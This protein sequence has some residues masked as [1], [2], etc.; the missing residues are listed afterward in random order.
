M[1]FGNRDLHR[2]QTRR[3]NSNNSHLRICLFHGTGNAGDQSASAD[4]RDN[5]LDIRDLLQNFQAHRALACNYDLIIEGMDE[6]H[7]ELLAAADGLFAGLVVIRAVKDDFGA[8]ALCRRSLDQRRRQRH[9]DLRANSVTAGVVGDSLGVVPRRG[10][11]Y[12]AGTL[13]GSQRQQ[14]V[15]RAAFLESAGALQ[16][17]ELEIN[18]IPGV[19][20]EIFRA[21]A[22]R[23]IDGVT[24][25]SHGRLDFG[26][27]H[28]RMAG[29]GWLRHED[30]F[31]HCMESGSKEFLSPLWGYY[32]LTACP[33]LAPWAALFRRFAAEL[34]WLTFA[35]T[36]IKFNDRSH[37]Y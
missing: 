2:W 25:A 9:T 5:G 37:G 30:W 4:R 3:L 18:R 23:Q 1:A 8:V 20:G 29:P 28:F 12:A 35:T 22:W 6:G 16:I 13:F 21:G 27:R 17:I 7:A 32:R 10:G 31:G 34:K 19:L 36:S 24:N 11:D 15:E 14:F 26:K 33:R